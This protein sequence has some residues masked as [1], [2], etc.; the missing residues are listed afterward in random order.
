MPK[1]NIYESV[2][3]SLA[4]QRTR[5]S[6]GWAKD[7]DVQ[8]GVTDLREGADPGREYGDDDQPNW[9]GPWIGLDRH[10]INELIRTLRQ[11]RDSAYG[12]DE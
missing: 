1:V 2:P 5:L 11:A 3:S 6:V 9:Q 10:Q 8:I 12:R 7:K 4:E